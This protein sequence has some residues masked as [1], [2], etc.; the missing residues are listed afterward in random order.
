MDRYRMV[1]V[2]GVDLLQEVTET[3]RCHEHLIHS[4][5]LLQLSILNVLTRDD[6]CM[7]RSKATPIRVTLKNTLVFIK[8]WLSGFHYGQVIW[9]EFRE[10]CI[11][12]LTICNR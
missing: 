5:V 2:V 12:Y 7:T 8:L 11:A 4:V 9:K 3:R 1:A 6:S 10:V